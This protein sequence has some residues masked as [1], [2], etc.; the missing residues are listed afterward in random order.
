M[1]FKEKRNI[2]VVIIS[3][4]IFCQLHAVEREWQLMYVF[5]RYFLRETKHKS[6][7]I[8]SCQS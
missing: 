1:F 8:F 5:I 2:V 6:S 7:F 3:I 4:L